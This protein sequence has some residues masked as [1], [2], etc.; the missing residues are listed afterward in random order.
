MIGKWAS[1]KR[2]GSSPL[3]GVGQGQRQSR[4]LKGVTPPPGGHPEPIGQGTTVV[5]TVPEIERKRKARKRPEAFYSG[6]TSGLE[7]DVV[8]YVAILEGLSWD[9]AMTSA[10]QLLYSMGGLCRIEVPLDA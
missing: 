8:F 5:R 10:R 4:W 1:G 2:S 3:A 9:K 7:N 6:N